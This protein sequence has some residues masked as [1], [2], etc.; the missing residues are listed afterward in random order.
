MWRTAGTSP[1]GAK[2]AKLIRRYNERIVECEVD[3]S[4]RIEEP[5]WI[6]GLLSSP[7]RVTVVNLP[8]IACA[9]SADEGADPR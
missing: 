1:I 5:V 2:K 3:Q 4:L 7:M 6:G 9:G 8:A